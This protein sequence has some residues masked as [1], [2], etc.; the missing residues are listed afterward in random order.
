MRISPVA[1]CASKLEK[2]LARAKITANVTHNH[3]EGVKGALAVV[4]CVFIRREATDLDAAKDK[5]RHTIPIKYGY[6]LN[7]TLDEIRPTYSFDVS[8]QGS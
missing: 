8:C 6:D 2:T 5:I 7:R 4:E 3:Q 1:L